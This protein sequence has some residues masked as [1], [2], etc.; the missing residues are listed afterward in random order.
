VL[1][2]DTVKK[3]NRRGKQEDRQF[4]ITED[5]YYII[6]KAIEKKQVCV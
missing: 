1:F 6:A 4:I 2:Y 3:V 5:A